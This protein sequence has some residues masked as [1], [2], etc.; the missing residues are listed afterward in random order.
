MPST[1]IRL[2]STLFASS[3]VITPLRPT[4][5]IASE[6]MLPTSMFPP[7]DTDAT[8]ASSSS[9][10]SLER[11]LSTLMSSLTVVSMPRVSCTG[12]VPAM[13][14]FMPSVIIAA[15]STVAVVVPSPARS[16][17][18]CAACRTSLAPTF[19]TGSS[20]STSLATVTPSLTILGDP[21][22][23]SSTTLR[24]LGPS[25]TPTTMASLSTPFCIFLS[26]APSCALKYS[27]LAAAVTTVDTLRA[28]RAVG[29]AAKVEFI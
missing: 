23:D 17:V 14:I 24:P 26:A 28:E 18:F 1:T 8:L 13:T 7:A 19:S 10:T 11:V 27:R 9:V 15:L 6:I 12:L 25:V 21:Y 16:L 22:L 5:A 20:S 4:L 3:S 2:L 29:N